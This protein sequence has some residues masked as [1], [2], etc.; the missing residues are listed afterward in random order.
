MRVLVLTIAGEAFSAGMDLN[1]FFR[2]LDDNPSE[3]ARARKTNRTW[4][5]QKVSTFFKPTIAMVK[6][7][8]F[9]EHLLL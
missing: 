7:Y 9:G 3:K 6:G 4:S 8:C 5:W 2:A 1:L